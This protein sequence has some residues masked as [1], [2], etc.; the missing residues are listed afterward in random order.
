MCAYSGTRT[1]YIIY[2]YFYFFIIFASRR[3]PKDKRVVLDKNTEKDVWWGEVN[4]PI[5]PDSYKLV[6]EVAVDY[7]NNRP[8]VLIQFFHN[9]H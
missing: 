1:G 6:E 5:P 9:F 7:L 8:K 3:S 4:I 2:F